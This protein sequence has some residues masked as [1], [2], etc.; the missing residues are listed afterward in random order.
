MASNEQPI[1]SIAPSAEAAYAGGKPAEQT[2]ARFTRAEKR[3]FANEKKKTAQ[4]PG[5]NPKKVPKR[6]AKPAPKGKGKGKGNDSVQTAVEA[7]AYFLTHQ[8]KDSDRKVQQTLS[9]ATNSIES[10]IT[11][12]APKKADVKK[13]EPSAKKLEKI[14]KRKEMRAE[15][16]QAWKA[17]QA[18]KAAQ[19]GAA[20]P[21]TESVEET[22]AA[23]A[24]AQAPVPAA[25]AASAQTAEE[26]DS[27]EAN[28]DDIF[29]D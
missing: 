27:F 7:I 3:A 29:D 5:K 10:R 2:K 25:A 16:K 26:S 14:Q 9:R 18:E 8:G 4:Q 23:P 28:F 19:E 13:A 15:K 20:A 6:D 24:L 21:V 11:R 17:Q 12:D 1:T 22:E